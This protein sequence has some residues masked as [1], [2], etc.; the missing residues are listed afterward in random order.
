MFKF[1]GQEN[2]TNRYRKALEEIEEYCNNVLS[3]TAVRT[4]ESDPQHHQQSERRRE[5][6]LRL[7]K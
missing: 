1:T 2:E 7:T 3:F 5:W 4:T 6:E